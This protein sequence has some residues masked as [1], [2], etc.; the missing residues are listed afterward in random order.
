MVTF[1]RL[2]LIGR[3]FGSPPKKATPVRDWQD[4]YRAA[5]FVL[6][7]FDSAVLGEIKAS[8]LSEV[9]SWNSNS[10]EASL[11][12]GQW[13]TIQDRHEAWVAARRGDAAWKANVA[14]HVGRSLHEVTMLYRHHPDSDELR[15]ALEVLGTRLACFDIL[16]EAVTSE[17]YPVANSGDFF[18]WGEPASLPD[19]PSER[20]TVWLLLEV[21]GVLDVA[22]ADSASGYREHLRKD[23]VY[24]QKINQMTVLQSF[25]SIKDASGIVRYETVQAMLRKFV[26]LRAFGGQGPALSVEDSA[27]EGMFNIRNDLWREGRPAVLARE[28]PVAWEPMTL[29]QILMTWRAVHAGGGTSIDLTEYIPGSR[30]TWGAWS[31]S[32]WVATREHIARTSGPSSQY[33]L[34]LSLALPPGWDPD[35]DDARKVIS[36]YGRWLTETEYQPPPS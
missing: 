19:V 17:P 22:I 12:A 8:Y 20:L 3:F 10:D 16:S 30:P 29:E 33:E 23:D 32:A 28:Q 18:A 2:P 35:S 31:G 24:V 7:S 11:L 5:C 26:W 9:N 13:D 34:G 36:Q 15:V 21:R 25:G 1:I 27:V 6:K 14:K 4:E